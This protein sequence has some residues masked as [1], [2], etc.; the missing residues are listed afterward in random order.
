MPKTCS[1][2]IRVEEREPLILGL[3]Q[4]QSLRAMA[5]V[6]GRTSNMLSHEHA[7][8]ASRGR[9]YRVCP[10]HT[11]RRPRTPVAP[12][13]WRYVRTGLVWGYSPA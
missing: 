8:K 10:A 1:T 3:A 9:S 7:R 2:H 11:R 12:W 13:L 6:V 5:T 4:G